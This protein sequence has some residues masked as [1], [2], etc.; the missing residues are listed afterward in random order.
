[1]NLFASIV[2]PFYNQEIHLLKEA[3][4][5]ALWQHYDKNEFEVIVVDDGSVYPLANSPDGKPS[6]RINRIWPMLDE[7]KKANPNFSWTFKTNGGTASALNTGIRMAKGDYIKWL[8]SDDVLYPN[9]LEEMAKAIEKLPEEHKDKCIIFSDYDVINENGNIIDQWIEPDWNSKTY[10]DR[11]KYLW[12]SF[13]GNASSSLIH[14][15][16]FE[17]VGLFDET[18]RHSE[19]YEFWLRSCMVYDY[20]LYHV[21]E[22]LLKYRSHPGQL[23]KQPGVF[24]GLDHVIRT[25]ILKK[26]SAQQIFEL[27]RRHDKDNP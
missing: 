24:G 16:I 21:Q 7:M 9:Y 22:Q 11:K 10:Y 25:N 6:V 5:S 26:M 12:M 20:D 23:S 14:R 2:I 8:S 3:I 18:V 13:Y 15:N 1:M 17:K 19:D 4:E 27:Y